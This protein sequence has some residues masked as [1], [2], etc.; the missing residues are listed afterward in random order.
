MHKL[1]VFDWVK[2]WVPNIVGHIEIQFVL[3]NFLYSQFKFL[4]LFFSPVFRVWGSRLWC[5]A[6]T[7]QAHDASGWRRCW[8]PTDATFARK[9]RLSKPEKQ[10]LQDLKNLNEK[11]FFNELMTIETW[12][13]L[14]Q[15]LNKQ[16]EKCFSLMKYKW[17]LFV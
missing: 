12:K 6:A 11:V 17:R 14:L 15:D 9:H 2:Y 7:A 16:N 3:S 5:R 10:L 4:V 13:K 8:T 1:V